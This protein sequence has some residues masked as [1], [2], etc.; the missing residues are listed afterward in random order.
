MIER[1][2][3]ESRIRLCVRYVRIEYMAERL[4]DLAT[5]RAIVFEREPQAVQ[6]REYGWTILLVRHH[7]PFRRNI[8]GRSDAGDQGEA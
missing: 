7:R 3:H 1:D 6:F 8:E 5:L 4:D 2:A